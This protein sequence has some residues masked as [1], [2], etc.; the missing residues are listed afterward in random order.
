MKDLIFVLAVYGT[1]ISLAILSVGAPW[2]VVGSAIDRLIFPS[3]WN[4]DVSHDRKGGAIR[5]FVHCPVCISFWVAAL[6]SWLFYSPSQAHLEIGY[7]WILVV[8]GLASVGIIWCVH[9][10]MTKLGQ[11]EV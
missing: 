5:I 1:A 4:A 9:V 10:V 6:F 3:R 2:R 8:D 11:Y 7:P